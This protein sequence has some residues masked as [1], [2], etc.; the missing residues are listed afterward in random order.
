MDNYS[1]VPSPTLVSTLQQLCNGEA[2]SINVV[3]QLQF[4]T[5]SPLRG[6]VRV[7]VLTQVAPWGSLESNIFLTGTICI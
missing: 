6:Y 2:V 5:A 3:T 1:I 4:T 7:Y